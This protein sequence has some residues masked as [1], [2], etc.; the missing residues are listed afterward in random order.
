M[1]STA[2]NREHAGSVF[3]HGDK[4]IARIPDYS[5]VWAN[6]GCLRGDGDLANPV[7][8]MREQILERHRQ[9]SKGAA[10][11]RKRVHP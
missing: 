5:T 8:L 1:A 11:S 10:G 9:L 6:P 7:A 2:G 4:N 3:S